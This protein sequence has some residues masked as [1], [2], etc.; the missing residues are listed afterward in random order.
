MAIQISEIKLEPEPL[1]AGKKVKATCKVTADTEITS[2]KVSDPR[3]LLLPMYDDGTH[4]DEMAADGIYTLVEEVPYD[5]DPGTYHATIIVK[6]E[7]GNT[8]RK[9]I[10]LRVA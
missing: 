8:E 10:E 3:Y 7:E 9:T 4:G 1:V 2:V 6:D 5:A